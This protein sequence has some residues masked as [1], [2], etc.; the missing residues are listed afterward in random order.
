M[1]PIYAGKEYKEYMEWINKDRERK[2]FPTPSGG[3]L[4][5]I[6]P[7]KLTSPEPSKH[8]VPLAVLDVGVFT[9]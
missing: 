9:F 6:F 3:L 5:S 7:L 1:F 8:N 4:L 2:V